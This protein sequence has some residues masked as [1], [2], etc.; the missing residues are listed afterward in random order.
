MKQVREGGANGRT[1][2][3][4]LVFGSLGAFF[5]AASG[6]T[7]LEAVIVWLLIRVPVTVTVSSCLAV[8]AASVSWASAVPLPARYSRPRP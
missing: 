5:I 2:I 3:A 1:R 4:M 6:V 8:G 7:G